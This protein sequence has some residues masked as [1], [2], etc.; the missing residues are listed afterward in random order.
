MGLF[1]AAWTSS[2]LSLSMILLLIP[3][4][5]KIERSLRHGDRRLYAP[6]RS[7]SWER[8][9]LVLRWVVGLKIFGSRF[10]GYALL[11]IARLVTL[12][13]VILNFLLSVTD[14][15]Y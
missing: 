5:G 15:Q 9:S 3:A 12:V 10:E 8:I 7:F 1:F 13:A 2:L 4:L 14:V 6:T 11:W